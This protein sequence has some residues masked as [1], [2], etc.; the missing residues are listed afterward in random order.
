VLLCPPEEVLDRVPLNESAAVVLMTHNY[1]HDLELLKALLNRRVRYI[2][3]LG[4]KRRAE[5]LLLE[6]EEEGES[7]LVDACRAQL[8][9][10][11]GLDIGAETPA[12][13]AFSIIVEIKAVL[14][15]RGGGL[16]RNRSGSIHSEV[17]KRGMTAHWPVGDEFGIATNLPKVAIGAAS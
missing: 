13:I 10:P 17:G 9:A 11:A 4:P 6:L 1:L 5:R 16:L 14:T 8:H 2:G 12:E 7:T 15:G 3:C